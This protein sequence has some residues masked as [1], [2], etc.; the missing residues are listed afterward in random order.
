M[1]I[2]TWKPL[3]RLPLLSLLAAGLLAANADAQDASTLLD[4]ATR[5]AG[6]KA[7][8]G[9]RVAVHVYGEPSLSDAAT[10]DEM[11][12]ITLPRVGLIQAGAMTIAELRDTVRARLSAV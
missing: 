2:I 3:V 9:D 10:L 8:P 7:R 4:L 11:G 6:M 1:A 12:R 5:A